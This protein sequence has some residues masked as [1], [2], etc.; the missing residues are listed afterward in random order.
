MCTSKP[1]DTDYPVF[2]PGYFLTCYSTLS[3]NYH[4]HSYEADTFS[5]V[6]TSKLALFQVLHKYIIST[7]TFVVIKSCNHIETI[8]LI[9][10]HIKVKCYTSTGF[11]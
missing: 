9:F 3:F 7:H 10:L 1:S 6:L 5:V 4:F 8:L 2:R 11:L